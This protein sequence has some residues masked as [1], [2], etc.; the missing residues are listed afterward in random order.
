MNYRPTKNQSASY[1]RREKSNV[2]TS[3]AAEVYSGYHSISQ[4]IRGSFAWELSLHHLLRFRAEDNFLERVVAG[5]DSWGHRYQSEIKL[6][7][8]KWKH[9]SSPP[10][11]KSRIMQSKGKIKMRLFFFFPDMKGPLLI[12]ILP[13]VKRSMTISNQGQACS[14]QGQEGRHVVLWS[15]FAPQQCAAT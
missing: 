9:P 2:I 4:T 8:E 7:N 12:E 11:K 5:D 10:P 14:N 6:Q 1:L 13:S 15:D 3:L